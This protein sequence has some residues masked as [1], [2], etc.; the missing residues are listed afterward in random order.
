MSESIINVKER[1]E[2][3]DQDVM[4]GL[5]PFQRA[6]V[7]H[8]A[9]LYESGQKRVLV[10]DEVGLGKTLIARG[11]ISKIALQRKE[12]GDDLVKIAYICS[13]GAIAA[14][15][16]ERLS[17]D[18][19]I[20][21]ARQS[22]S[23][24]SM[25]HLIVAR[26]RANEGLK[27]RYIQITPLTPGTSF[28]ITSGTGTMHERALIL[29]VLSYYER[30]S[31]ESDNYQRLADLMWDRRKNS[32]SGGWRWWCWYT[33]DCVRKA[34]EADPELKYPYDVLEKVDAE[35]GA[36]GR[37]TFESL[38]A[39]LVS[40][41]HDKPLERR[42]I[43]DLRRAFAKACVELLNPD[44][45]IMDE[46]QRF[47]SLISDDDSETS[48]LAKR[49]L[50]GQTR[51]LLLSATPFRMYSTDA[52]LDTG[53]LGDSYHEFLEVMDFLGGENHENH[54]VFK[55]TWG[56]YTVSLRSLGAG[57]CDVVSIQSSKNAAEDMARQ[58]IARTERQSTG[59]LGA[60]VDNQTHVREIE[61][62]K[63]DIQAYTKM[64]KLVRDVGIR[65]L[66]NTDY[67]KSCPFPLSFMSDYKLF[68]ELEKKVEKRPSLV[69]ASKRSD[70]GLLWL[71]RW[72][73]SGYSKIPV[74]NARFQALLNDLNADKHVHPELLLWVPASMPY[75]SPSKGSPF[76]HAAGFSKMI[77]FSSW[78]MVPRALSC[79]L[80][81]EFERRNV[82]RLEKVTG[83][84]YRYFKDEEGA[85]GDEHSDSQALPMR[86][87]RFDK[88]QRT[89]FFLL[90]PSP[91]LA[92]LVDTAAL[93]SEPG[94]LEDL[95][96]HVREMIRVNLLEAL[97]MDALP[98]S[99]EFGPRASNEWYLMAPLLL[100]RAHGHDVLGELLADHGAA[101]FRLRD[102]YQGEYR[103]LQGI[104]RDMNEWSPTRL[105]R[106]PSD[107]VEV[108]ADA[109]IGSP[110]VCAMRTYG[111]YADDVPLEL[112]FEF[113]HAFM[114]RMNTSSATLTVAAAME[115]PGTTSVHWKNLL[116]YACEG[117]LQAVL[118][119]YAYLQ[120]PMRGDLADAEVVRRIHR[121]MVGGGDDPDLNNVEARHWV[122]V[123]NQS[124][125]SERLGRMS[126]RT[127]IAA[128]FME[129]KSKSNGEGAISRVNLRNAFNSPFRPFVLVSTSV[130]QE[131]LDFHQYCR[132]ICH[133]NLPSNPI[134]LEQREGRVNR[135]RGLS[136]RQ[137][138]VA[139]YANMRFKP[140]VVWEQLFKV[141]EREELAREGDGPSS[142]LL[143]NW[144]VTEGKSMVQV[145][146]YAYLYP[147]S[148]DVEQYRSLIE[149][150][151]RYRVVLGQ[152][153]QEELLHMLQ[154]RVDDGT[155]SE[156]DLRSLFVNLCP[157][158]WEGK[159]E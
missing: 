135:Y 40:G 149:Q 59:E 141:A 38:S 74:G 136:V 72:D 88:D 69:V 23:R 77:L 138:I 27:R 67:V 28:S 159:G 26:E 97:G 80:S 108:L 50:S 13:N 84:Q 44:F 51:V 109:A 64:R 86:R 2:E 75:Y 22:E 130:G 81:Y 158:V 58:Y 76:E 102:R 116:A 115:R 52:E 14:Q 20:D 19:D 41:E 34:S 144:G 62:S 133:W 132:K 10:A 4:A 60:I 90:Y 139:R 24:L 126:M 15:N 140:G 94:S 98:D 121:N 31:K 151:Y 154:D 112:P 122:Q 155:L 93:A 91:Y 21:L 150:V 125:A 113:G 119:E 111:A 56:D 18:N 6:T 120:K 152:P 128:A 54:Q 106:C 101:G 104:A 114:D 32:N 61:V 105:G 103:V 110:A 134:D 142:G 49:F 83:R 35:L 143:P 148:R 117:N 127:N 37:T 89:G 96:R 8:I 85:R 42:M 53:G 43:N 66:M 129:S 11:V 157:F 29:A 47:R 95:R 131:G 63:A 68:K 55:K 39:Y 107:L 92:G 78:A 7:E 145:E 71:R 57:T 124:H 82:E 17:I 79:L 153:D 118:D 65:G 25:Q 45:V 70:K 12:E 9:Q 5:T 123:P 87:L 146:R 147:F 16:I 156:D 33:E 46:F 73:V 36:A 1:L 48:I 99:R 100:D 137:S 30:F 3:I